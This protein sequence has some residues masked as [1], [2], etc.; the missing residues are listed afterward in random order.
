[1][2]AWAGDE[3]VVVG[4]RPWGW[5]AQE[6]SGKNS[7]SVSAKCGF[8]RCLSER[9]QAGSEKYYERI[10]NRGSMFLIYYMSVGV[11]LLQTV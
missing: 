8:W 1:M 3:V 4:V 6:V 11:L 7:L 9:C 2:D 10:D 5:R